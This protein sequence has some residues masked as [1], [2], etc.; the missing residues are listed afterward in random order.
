MAKN[1]FIFMFLELILVIITDVS[2]EIFKHKRFI[3]EFI[4][5]WFAVVQTIIVIYILDRLKKSK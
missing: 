3:P 5:L 1:W 4:F 2:L